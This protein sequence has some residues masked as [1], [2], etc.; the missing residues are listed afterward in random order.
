[1][2]EKLNPK[3]VATFEEVLLSNVYTQEAW[4]NLIAT[5]GIIKK[6]EILEEVKRLRGR[7]NAGRGK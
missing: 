4:I 1:M 5:K 3:E 6:A 2:A 7:G